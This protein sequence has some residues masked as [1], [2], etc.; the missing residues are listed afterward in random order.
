L[1][2]FN[3]PKGIYLQLFWCYFVNVKIGCMFAEYNGVSL[4]GKNCKKSPMNIML[5]LPN[6]KMLDF[7]FCNFRCIVAI[8]LLQLTMKFG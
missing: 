8:N 7:I 4:I 6:G 3:F 2:K 5:I 1:V